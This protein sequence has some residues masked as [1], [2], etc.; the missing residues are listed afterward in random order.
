VIANEQGLAF[1]AVFKNRQSVTEDDSK[2]N[3][4]IVER[5]WRYSSS[6]NHSQ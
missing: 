1:V 4:E 5:V 6:G 3:A 2:P